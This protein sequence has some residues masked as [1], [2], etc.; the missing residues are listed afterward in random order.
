MQHYKSKNV[1]RVMGAS[2]AAVLA[3]GWLGAGAASAHVSPDKTEVSAEAYTDVQLLVPHGCDGE[4]TNKVEVQV[5]AQLLSASPDVIPG[6][7]ATVETEPLDTPITDENG[8]EITER[9]SVISWTAEPGN[10]LL[11]G[12]RL[13][14]GVGFQA[15][16][17]VGETMF[18]KTIQTCDGATA[19]W[20]TEWDG[21]GEEPDKPAPAVMIVEGSGDGHG[22]AAAAEDESGEA[23]ADDATGEAST[24]TETT[25]D[26][27]DDD[28]D[29]DDDDSSMPVAV[30]GLVAGV[31]GL[32]L[33]GAAFA[34]S[35]KD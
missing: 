10:E 17:A 30:A 21:S 2:A 29:D 7:K 1:I 26:D 24:E 34:K 6:W 3:V 23:T 31:A 9:D 28:D 15:P 8:A 16:D 35:R 20:V 5:P 22:A 19:E 27:S 25:D 32:G 33:G 11:D 4:A 18:F 13:H 12:Q 14:F